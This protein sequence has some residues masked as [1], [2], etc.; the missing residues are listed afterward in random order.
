[1]KSFLNFLSRNK[2][3][4]FIEV[5]GMAVALY[6]RRSNLANT[7]QPHPQRYPSRSYNYRHRRHHC[8]IRLL[9][10]DD[11]QTIFSLWFK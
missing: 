6:R 9:R 1:M 4:T 2:L 8:T 5:V 11:L 10:S 7:H 3:Y